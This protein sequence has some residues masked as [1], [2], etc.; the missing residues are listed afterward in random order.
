MLTPFRETTACNIQHG[1]NTQTCWKLQTKSYTACL[2]RMLHCLYVKTGKCVCQN[3]HCAVIK[4]IC[5]YYAYEEQKGKER[6]QEEKK[7][8]RE[9]KTQVKRCCNYEIRLCLKA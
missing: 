6:K 7:C 9:R 3:L 5:F 4:V 8:E 2:M 1:R